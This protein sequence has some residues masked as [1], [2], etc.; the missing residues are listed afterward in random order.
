M[1]LLR[2]RKAGYILVALAT[3][4]LVTTAGFGL[5]NAL[6]APSAT[7]PAATSESL[8]PAP[9]LSVLGNEPDGVSYTDLGER[10]S[11]A[12]CYRAV[13]LSSDEFD[14]EQTIETVYNHLLS[15]GWGRMLPQGET[16]PD[17]VALADSA[18]TNGSFVVRGNT[19]PFT[20][21]STAG[22]VIVHAQIDVPST[23][24]TS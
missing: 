10:C 2:S 13:A 5:I 12:E 6:T 19:E 18:M 14:G 21:D 23:A 8:P 3:A 4:G 24:P 9:E 7:P 16:D 17:Q 20:E 22:L 1:E 15:Q 11:A